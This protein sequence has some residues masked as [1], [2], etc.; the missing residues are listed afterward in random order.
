MLFWFFGGGLM[1]YVA[2]NLLDDQHFTWW[3]AVPIGLF[4]G[5]SYYVIPVKFNDW[6]EKYCETNN[7]E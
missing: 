3:I 4:I 2:A 5:I 1:L 7:P 6:R